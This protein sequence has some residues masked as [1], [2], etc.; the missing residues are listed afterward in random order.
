MKH[1]HVELVGNLRCEIY[2]LLDVFSYPGAKYLSKFNKHSAVA[3]TETTFP[4]VVNVLLFSANLL[5]SVFGIVDNLIF[6]HYLHSNPS[7]PT[8]L[9]HF[10][11]TLC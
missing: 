3:S 1:S 4:E 6:L 2:C 11:P 7:Y 10:C 5:I 9:T 8:N